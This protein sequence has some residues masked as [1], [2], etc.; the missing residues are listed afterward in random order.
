MGNITGAG[1]GYFCGWTYG[2]ELRISIHNTAVQ[3]CTPRNNNDARKE[4]LRKFTERLKSI[5]H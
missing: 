1:Q 2:A 5:S 4:L 3:Q